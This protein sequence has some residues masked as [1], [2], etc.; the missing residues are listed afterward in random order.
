VV[1]NLCIRRR[2]WS[3][4]G[5]GMVAL[6]CIGVIAGGLD[7]LVVGS[8]VLAQ[9]A[10]GISSSP[11]DEPLLRPGQRMRRPFGWVEIRTFSRSQKDGDTAFELEF[12]V[13]NESRNTMRNFQAQNL[14]RL[15]ADDVPRAPYSSE[16]DWPKDILPDSAEYCNAK[17][18]VRGTPHVVRV[19]FGTVDTGRTFLRWPE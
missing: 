5:W 2:E 1:A 12:L 16:P 13:I 4:F 18:S 3:V 19:Q 14:V 7:V 6:T 11:D 15:I 9:P 8:P 17:F 10:P